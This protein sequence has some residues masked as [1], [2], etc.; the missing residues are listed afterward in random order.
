MVLARIFNEAHVRE[1]VLVCSNYKSTC[2]FYGFRLI[3]Y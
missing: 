2:A 3:L 1:V